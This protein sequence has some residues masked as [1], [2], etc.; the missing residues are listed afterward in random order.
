M[1]KYLVKMTKISLKNTN[2]P[3]I[4]FLDNISLIVNNKT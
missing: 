2:K 4:N 1:C 3:S